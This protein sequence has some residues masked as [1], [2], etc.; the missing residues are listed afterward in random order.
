MPPESELIVKAQLCGDT[1]DHSQELGTLE[2]TNTIVSTYGLM[3]P[4]ALVKVDHNSVQCTLTNFG[5]MPVSV[6]KGTT[7]VALTPAESVI[8]NI[9]RNKDTR[10]HES[11][12]VEL[13][14]LEEMVNTAAPHLTPDQLTKLWEL[15]AKKANTFVGPDGKLGCTQHIK[16]TIDTGNAKPIKLP[17]RH[18]SEAHQEIANREMDKMLEQGI[19]E[20][21]DS[22]WA[23][24]IVLIK[25][26]DNTIRFCID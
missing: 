11:N 15:V 19:I 24:P 10:E 16:H 8:S 17:P 1:W 2:P 26:K 14:H 4:R 22:P 23:S 12:P 25:K 3:V 21:C 5:S 9:V 7:V 18:L 13:A 20:P 6:R